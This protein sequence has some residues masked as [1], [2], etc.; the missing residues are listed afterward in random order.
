MPV[1]PGQTHLAAPGGPERWRTIDATHHVLGVIHN[2]TSATR[3]LDLLSVFEGDTR[4]QVHFTCTGSSAFDGGMREFIAAREMPC[5]PWD[6]ACEL[7]FD[8]AVSS[9]RG[10]ELQDI[11]APLICAPHGAGYNKTLSREPGA[12]SREPGAGSREPGAGSREP[13]AFGLTDE[14]L[15]HDG[16][17]IPSAIVLSHDEQRE[18]LRDGCPDA[19]PFATVVGDPCADQLRASTPFR[20]AY[21]AALGVRPGQKLLVLTSTWGRRSLLGHG[22][23]TVRRALAELPRDEYRVVAAVHPNAW[24]G[25]GGWQVH[26]W[27]A[28]FVRAGLVLPVPETDTWKAALTAADAFIGDHGSVTLYGVALGLPGLLGAFDDDVVAPGSPMALLGGLLPRVAAGRPLAGQLADAAATQPGDERLAEVGSLVTSRPMRSM[29]LLR[30]LFYE[31]LGLPEP[32]DPAVVRPVAT[33]RRPHDRRRDPAPPPV[34]ATARFEEHGGAAATVTVRH[35]PA[36]VQGAE[37]GHL[38][39]PHLVA[40]EGEPDV[41]WL[42]TADIVLARADA[43]GRPTGE[44]AGPL[45]DR[46]PGCGAVAVPEPAGLTGDCGLALRDGPE[47]TARWREQQWWTTPQTAAATAYACLARFGP[48]WEGEITVRAGEHLPPAVLT[49]AAVRRG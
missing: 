14:W 37:A 29:A 47:L 25:H 46:Y 45:F 43:T 48:A 17:L 31:H 24:H 11:S 49:V 6:E 44:V 22:G 1:L 21:R 42:H 41:R 38:P 28:P 34:F 16:R 39:D 5:I 27:L 30:G 23:D 2:V 12:G 10:G 26:T 4:I 3:L 18:R 9:S 8:L 7:K 36:A 32:A 20:D 19:V 13:G 15:V 35:Y 33:P 40:V